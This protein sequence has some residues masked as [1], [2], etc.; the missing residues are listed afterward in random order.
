MLLGRCSPPGDLHVLLSA[1]F[2]ARFSSTVVGSNESRTH[3]HCFEFSSALRA[4]SEL[5]DQAHQC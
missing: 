5:A 1:E 3:P 2:V 4:C